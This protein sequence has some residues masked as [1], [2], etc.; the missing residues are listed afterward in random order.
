MRRNTK[1]DVREQSARLHPTSVQAL[2]MTRHW[3]HA[4][5]LA[6]LFLAPTLEAQRPAP[7]R[8]PSPTA[9]AS[10]AASAASASASVVSVVA[11]DPQGDTLFRTPGVL[12]AADGLVATFSQAIA[13]ETRLF[14]VDANGTASAASP[15]LPRDTLVEAMLVRAPGS[16]AAP[17]R[18]ASRDLQ[19]RERFRILLPQSTGTPLALSG[20]VQRVEAFDGGNLAVLTL[21]ADSVPNGAPLFTMDDE[22]IGLAFS[23][24]Q[25]GRTT[26]Y[27][28]PL[29]TMQRLS[30]MPRRAMPAV[31]SAP[32]ATAPT[33]TAPVAAST[34]TTAPTTTPTTTR[35]QTTATRAP[36]TAT[37]SARTTELARADLVASGLAN[38][39]LFQRLFAGEM[40]TTG[41]TRGDLGFAAMLNQYIEACAVR[42]ES[43]LPPDRVELT[44]SECVTERVTRN[45]YG[46]EIDRT[47]IESV[48]V[49]RG[50]YADPRVL[51]VQRSRDREF[52]VSTVQSVL[53]MV[54]SGEARGT[55]LQAV[56]EGTSFRK[57]WL[58]LLEANGCTS[59]A[60]K[61]VEENLLRF[62]R[63]EEAIR[64]P[65]AAAVALADQPFRESNYQQ[66]AESLIALD[67]T[68]WMFNRFVSGSVSDVEVGSRDAQGHPVRVTGRYRYSALGTPTAGQFSISFAAGAPSCVTFTDAPEM[69]RPVS[70]G[71]ALEYRSGRYWIP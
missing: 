9:S 48:D 55:M 66:L 53:G 13:A 21:S 41:M 27:G 63:G 52:A 37:R 68:T 10:P 28:L 58:A 14:V 50:V 69:C 65:G 1:A 12:L 25:D 51:A 49:G 26:N 47:C 45:G 18:L 56:A 7:T 20:E 57:D 44:R 17:A 64:L 29:G 30:G 33:V 59:P 43:S 34:A 11:L 60:V 42:C 5:R 6:C 36:A 2:V 8:R 70:R 54:T 71:A 62:A 38:A 24:E 35:T 61:R 3:L 23:S 46:A 22:F 32:A 31:A 39:A 16:G 67:A 4:V 40:E 19:G 15:V